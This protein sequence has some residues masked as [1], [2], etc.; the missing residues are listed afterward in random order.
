MAGALVPAS[1]GQGSGQP[2]EQWHPPRDLPNEAEIE[3]VDFP[4][5]EVNGRPGIIMSYDS[6]CDPPR[7]EVSV[8]LRKQGGPEGELREV[9]LNL[10]RGH[11]RPKAY[12]A[13]GHMAMASPSTWMMAQEAPIGAGMA[14]G[15]VP[16]QAL[17]AGPPQGAQGV[18][19][20]LQ[21][22]IAPPGDWNACGQGLQPYAC[23]MHPGHGLTGH[24]PQMQP[25]YGGPSLAVGGQADDPAVSGRLEEALLHR[26][27]DSRGSVPIPG[28]GPAAPCQ[29]PHVQQPQ[30]PHQ[31]QQQ[32]QQPQQPPQLPQLPQQQPPQQSAQGA[33]PGRQ[34][35][36]GPCG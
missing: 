27:M 6:G 24:A 12:G 4:V 19:F 30:Q 16:M 31:Q 25:T 22:G 11:L 17:A 14:F 36:G 15:A 1:R 18:C 3:I 34:V 7:Y 21:P 8:M 33:A 2:P 29:G 5:R 28:Y 23:G 13:C 10:R 9:R 35:F 26:L 20:A 32:P